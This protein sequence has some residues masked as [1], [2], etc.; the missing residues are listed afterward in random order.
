[1]AVR[2]ISVRFTLCIAGAPVVGWFHLDARR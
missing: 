1:V 2:M